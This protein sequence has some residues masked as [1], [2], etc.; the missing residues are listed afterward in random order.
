MHY[1]EIGLFIFLLAFILSIRGELTIVGEPWRLVAMLEANSHFSLNDLR[2]ALLY[3]ML[4][5]AEGVALI[6]I[7]YV[8]EKKTFFRWQLAVAGGII[9]FWGLWGLRGLYAS[10]WEVIDHIA[11]YNIPM[12]NVLLTVY[13]V[14]SVAKILWLFAGVL[15][16]YPYLNSTLRNE[17]SKYTHPQDLY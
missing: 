9:A 7:G 1:V 10:Y 4:P 2:D 3:S 16:M 11:Q 17:W 15:S 12:D 8:K 14:V 6:I 13:A 5:P